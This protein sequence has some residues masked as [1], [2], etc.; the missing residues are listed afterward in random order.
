[1]IN[2]APTKEEVEKYNKGN[3]IPVGQSVKHNYAVGHG[4]G[5]ITEHNKL[6]SGAYNKYA[7]PYKVQF[8]SG[9]IDYYAEKDLKILS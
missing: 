1:M 9:Y 3:F 2:F 5:V 6:E 8:E 7:Y 4:K